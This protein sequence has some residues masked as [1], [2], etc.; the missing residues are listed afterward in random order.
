MNKIE[1]VLIEENQP[2]RMNIPIWLNK[3]IIGILLYFIVINTIILLQ[4]GPVFSPEEWLINPFKLLYLLNHTA[5]IFF[6]ASLVAGWFVIE[7]K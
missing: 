7:S 1:N 4:T 5:I 3:L 2:R 6:I